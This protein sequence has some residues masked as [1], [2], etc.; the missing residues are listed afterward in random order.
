MVSAQ[1]KSPGS[2]APSSDAGL[3]LECHLQLLDVLE[4]EPRQAAVLLLL[5]VGVQASSFHPKRRSIVRKKGARLVLHK[6]PK[7]S[8][9]FSFRL[10]PAFLLLTM[11]NSV[12]VVEKF[13]RMKQVVTVK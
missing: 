13:G 9:L 3:T 5:F 12:R 7:I 2:F 4:A 10:I 1:A 8:A 11:D 6:H